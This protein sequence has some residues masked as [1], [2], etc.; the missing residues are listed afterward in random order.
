MRMRIIQNVFFLIALVFRD[1]LKLL[2]H[3]QSFIATALFVFVFDVC[4]SIQAL[5]KVLFLKKYKQKKDRHFIF[6]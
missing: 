3:N 2:F 6:Y 4:F 1:E 5:Q